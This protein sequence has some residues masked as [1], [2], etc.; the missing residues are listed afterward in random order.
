M[1]SSLDGPPSSH[2]E[3]SIKVCPITSRTLNVWGGCEELQLETPAESMKSVG[4]GE[5]RHPL[6]SLHGPLYTY[7][8]LIESNS[9]KPSGKGISSP[10][11]IG[12]EDYKA[13]ELGGHEG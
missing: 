13:E 12:D 9:G 11:T 8:G 6:R 4:A 10:S 1:I 3:T 2:Q 5:W 7:N